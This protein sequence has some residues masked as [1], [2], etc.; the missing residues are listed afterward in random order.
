[1]GNNS[2]DENSALSETPHKVSISQDFWL[3]QFEVTREQWEK[4]MGDNERHPEKP[5]PFSKDN[6]HYPVVSKSYYDIQHFIGKLNELSSGCLFR[7][8]SEAEWEYA[9]RAKTNTPFSFGIFIS[10]S[11]ANFNAEIQSKYAKKGVYI[12]HPL[13]V[14]SYPANPWG[15]YDMHGNVWEWV[16]DWYAPYPTEKQINPKGP[17]VGTLKVIRGGSWYFSADNS[18]SYIRWTHEPGLWGFSIGFRI[19]CEKK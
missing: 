2:N 6:P 12:G 8:P 1:M 10:D 11:L 14:G 13:P 7:L 17:P 19:V 3:G 15:L 16:E 18:Q 9:C 5:S 4:I